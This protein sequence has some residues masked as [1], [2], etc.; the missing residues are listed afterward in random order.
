[1]GQTGGDG[2]IFDH[3]D[4]NED[5]D[6]PKETLS[7]IYKKQIVLIEVSGNDF[8]GQILFEEKQFQFSTS[9]VRK[10]KEKKIKTRSSRERRGA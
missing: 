1:M 4:D 5:E 3:D 8:C 2:L 6:K 9:V 10:M 7:P